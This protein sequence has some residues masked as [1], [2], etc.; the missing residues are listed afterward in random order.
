MKLIWSLIIYDDLPCI[1]KA[2][3][4]SKRRTQGEEQ[5]GFFLPHV[6][7]DTTITNDNPECKH[8]LWTVMGSYVLLK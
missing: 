7:M 1:K 5:E 8:A 3:T 6:G 4:G 2:R